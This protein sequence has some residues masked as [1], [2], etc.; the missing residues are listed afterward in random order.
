VVVDDTVVVPRQ[1]NGLGVV[2]AAGR[3]LVL[4]RRPADVEGLVLIAHG[5][6]SDSCERQ[7]IGFIARWIATAR[8]A[9]AERASALLASIFVGIV[10]DH[11]WSFQKL[12]E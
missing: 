4:D 8:G 3:M 5:V 1:R 6:G 11:G 7:R 9:G 2:V 10:V 12:V